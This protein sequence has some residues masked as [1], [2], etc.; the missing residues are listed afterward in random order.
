[1]EALH[2]ATFPEEVKYFYCA[3]GSA[4]CRPVRGHENIDFKN[5]PEVTIL[6]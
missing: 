5:Q 6:C 3:L 2:N 4:P 1:M